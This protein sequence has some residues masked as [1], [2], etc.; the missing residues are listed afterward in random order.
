MDKET[1]QNADDIAELERLQ[2]N[3]KKHEE[4]YE[5]IRVEVEKGVREL[6]DVDKRVVKLQEK[7]KDAKGRVK[8]LEK[9][10]KEV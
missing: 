2:E 1:E 5:E 3:L 8:K 6:R 4:A 10:V 7:E 9:S